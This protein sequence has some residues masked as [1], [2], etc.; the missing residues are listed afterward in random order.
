V[1][2]SCNQPDDPRRLWEDFLPDFT[3]DVLYRAREAGV[4][5]SPEEA[6][7]AALWEVELFLRRE[8]RTLREWPSM[9]YPHAP[10]SEPRVSEY[11][12]LETSYDAAAQARL[13]ADM[14]GMLNDEQRSAFD[15][16]CDALDSP[17]GE[18]KCFFLYACGGCGKTFVLRLLLAHVRAKR[19]IAFQTAHCVCFFCM[20]TCFLVSVNVFLFSCLYI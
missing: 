13:E 6:A 11:R 3:E 16:I 1:I 10:Q 14:L 15:A 2:L 19:Q 8:G 20:C 9:P 18:A 4:R 7:N 12:K 17:S 5:M